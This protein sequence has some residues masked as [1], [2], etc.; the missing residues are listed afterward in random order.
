MFEY[1]REAVHVDFASALLDNADVLALIAAR[2]PPGILALLDE[3]CATPLGDDAGFLRRAGD[4]DI[5][6][7]LSHELN[8]VPPYLRV[9]R[10]CQ[11]TAEPPP[12]PMHCR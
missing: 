12:P 3:T 11:E 5:W 9:A 6:A 10:Q 2:R 7:L 8:T 4:A 1:A